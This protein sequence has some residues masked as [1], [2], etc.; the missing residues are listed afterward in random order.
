MVTF[1]SIF[2][3]SIFILHKHRAV[4]IRRCLF[5]IGVLYLMRT[6]SLM[7]TQLPSG[8]YNNT[9]ECRDQL[10]KTERTITVY[11]KRVLEQ[12]IH[13]GLQVSFLY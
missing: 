12:S 1:A 3:I 7:T 10:N 9:Q 11:I 8:Y 2:M 13:F 6:L 5:I 4:V